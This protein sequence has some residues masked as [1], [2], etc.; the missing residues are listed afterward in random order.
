MKKTF[1]EK[2]VDCWID[3]AF[4]TGHAMLKLREMIHNCPNI[5]ESVE[6]SPGWC[7][8][9]ITVQVRE[10]DTILA[11]GDP[12]KLSDDYCEFDEAE[13]ILQDNTEEGLIWVWESGN[14]LLVDEQ[15]WMEE[16]Y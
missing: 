14:L 13:S 10:L 12:E 2:D 1:T 7:D 9:R 5:S 3:G 16:D 6:I 11:T 15:K 8:S 4:G